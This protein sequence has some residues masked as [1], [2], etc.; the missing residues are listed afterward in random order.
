MLPVRDI[1]QA[2][3]GHLRRAVPLST[4]YHLLHRLTR[5]SLQP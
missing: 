2:L 4:V 1:R 3:D 5:P